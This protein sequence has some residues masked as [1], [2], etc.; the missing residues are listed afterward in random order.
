MELNFFEK[1]VG[2]V[3]PGYA[4]KRAED[5]VA[6][7]SFV[8]LSAGGR[9]GGG[10]ARGQNASLF[11]QAGAEGPQKQRKRV[12][13]I[14]EGR[15][16]E[17]YLCIITGILERTTQYVCDNME[18]R[19]ATG[20]PKTDK[21][22][23]DYF[24][25]WCKRAD[26]G[27]RHSFGTLVK[28]ALRASIRDGEFGFVEHIKGG[29]LSLQGITADRIGNPTAFVQSETNLNGIH[30]NKAGVV[31]AYDIYK[32][33]VNNQYSKE[34]SVT[35]KRFIHL[36]FPTSVDQYHG[37]SKLKPALPHARDL[38][39]L[40]GYEKIAAKFAASFAGFV[41]KK[42]TSNNR[43]GGSW[44]NGPDSK[45]GGTAGSKINTMNAA[46]GQVRQL[47]YDEEVSFAPGTMR[48]SGAFMQLLDAIIREIA[49]SL[50]LP[51]GFVYNMASFGGVTARLETAQAQRVFKS[52][53]KRLEEVILNRVKN[54]VL[55]LGIAQGRIP[56]SKQWQ[57][58]DWKYGAHITGDV[59]HQVQA[60]AQLVNM[61]VKTRTTWATE[62]GSDFEE[63]AEQAG[64]ELA[65]LQRVS[66][67][68]K[69]PMELLNA[70]L[71]N[72]TESIANMAKAEAG[73]SDELEPAPGLIGEQ[74]E[75]GVKPLIDVLENYGNGL[76]DRDST[77]ALLMEM[78]AMDYG[79][80]SLLVPAAAAPAA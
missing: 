10:R 73:I 69:V 68:Y 19:A 18:Y 31:Q 74:G 36:F 39:E 60:D 67:K 24:H 52:Y 8:E 16:M 48:P 47:G 78:Y 54:K 21:A 49:I 62:L 58:G 3:S 76:A 61:G 37:V 77:I 23:E 34:G 30:V 46:P 17:E 6:L 7:E 51:Y 66:E 59:G 42:D 35:P 53:Q 65:M 70:S 43:T 75:K 40:L 71:Q 22:Y 25:A 27:G 45:G 5:R 38:Y 64:A 56:S 55:M 12:A 15:A 44:D 50:N 63:L 32:R 41:K 28:L 14:W 72:A 11:D 13:A 2:A 4:I 26:Y 57:K 20:D 1:V 79:R 80:A 29:E 33:S 9:G